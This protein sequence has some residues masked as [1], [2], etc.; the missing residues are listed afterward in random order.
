MSTSEV[1]IQQVFEMPDIW[2][3]TKEHMSGRTWSPV[4]VGDDASLHLLVVLANADGEPG[5]QL[6]IVE[7]VHDTKHLAL[8]KA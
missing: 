3:K 4:L 2:L 1:F 6:A 5:A 7:G 8:I